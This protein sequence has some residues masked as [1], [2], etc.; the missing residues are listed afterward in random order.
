MTYDLSGRDG[1]QAIEYV[2]VLRA[3]T[4]HEMILS[5]TVEMLDRYGLTFVTSWSARRDGTMFHIDLNTRPADY[6][7]RYIHDD[8]FW[9]DPVISAM[10]RTHAS[11]SWSDVTSKFS[12]TKAELTLIDEGRDFGANN[13]LTVPIFSDRF[14]V[15]AFSACGWNPD[16]SPNARS[17]LN[18]VAM[19]AHQALMRAKID[20]ARCNFQHVD[21]TC[22]ER[23]IMH[24]VANG[25][26]NRD[27]ATI[28]AIS[29]ATVKT[30]LARAQGKLN[31]SGRTYAA[32]Q[33][34]RC[35]ELDL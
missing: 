26:S 2:S 1:L 28:L 9:R 14:R 23:E 20:D 12:W 15:G 6:I 22:R 4:S 34:L 32:V 30:T 21:L 8:L 7:E 16:L 29:S 35:G 13:G 11:L 25:K 3:A 5:L 10:R 33:A 18:I 19:S 24:W 31:A 27:I 17:V